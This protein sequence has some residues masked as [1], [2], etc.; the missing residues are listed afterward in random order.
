MSSYQ[1]I[2]TVAISDLSTV[3]ITISEKKKRHLGKTSSQGT[4]S[5]AK[6]LEIFQFFFSGKWLLLG[7]L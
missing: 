4:M 5:K 2:I 6:N 1:L 7:L 3:T